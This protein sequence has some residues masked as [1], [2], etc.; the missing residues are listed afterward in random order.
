MIKTWR[1]VAVSSLRKGK[2]IVGHHWYIIMRCSKL[3]FQHSSEYEIKI[4]S[5][6]DYWINWI[7]FSAGN[8]W[9]FS[10]GTCEP[11]LE[12]RESTRNQV[13]GHE[14][15]SP[16]WLRMDFQGTGWPG[17]ES[18]RL[19]V[20]LIPYK[21]KLTTLRYSIH[22]RGIFAHFSIHLSEIMLI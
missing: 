15:T 20:D 10:Q 7:K 13:T 12:R 14:L 6:L 17:Y 3:P 4:W 8:S 16:L 5:F 1:N 18:V 11:P 21:C 2:I 19:Q 22:N 9:K